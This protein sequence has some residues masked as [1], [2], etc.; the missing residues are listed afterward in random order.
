MKL[1][2]Y[3]IEY[4]IAK[5]CDIVV[6]IALAITLMVLAITAIVGLAF[7]IQHLIKLL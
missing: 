7:L 4:K 2:L 5:I 1:D 6:N 3:D